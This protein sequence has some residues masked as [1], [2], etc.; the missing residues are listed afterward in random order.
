MGSDN[1]SWRGSLESEGVVA[2]DETRMPTVLGRPRRLRVAEEAAAIIGE[3]ILRGDYGLGSRLTEAKNAQALHISRNTLREAFRI[4]ASEGLVRLEPHRG[5]RVT[6]L[7]RDDVREIFCVRR[8]LELRA[9]EES[10]EAPP[11][12]LADL[13]QALEGICDL[14]EGGSWFEKAAADVEFHRSLVAL[15]GSAKLNSMYG[16]IGPL[17]QLLMVFGYQAQPNSYFQD[18]LSWIDEHQEIYELVAQE[19][20]GEGKA[21]LERNLAQNEAYALSLVEVDEE[22]EHTS[23]NTTTVVGV[24]GD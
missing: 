9:I 6:R 4:L 1:G 10:R 20:V 11:E 18:F 8:A 16:Q 13:R 14:A 17:S 22:E 3:H 2:N 21:R 24:N 19:R 7:K 5:A 15:I 23:S 12:R